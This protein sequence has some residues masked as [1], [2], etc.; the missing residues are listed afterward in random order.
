VSPSL[1]VLAPMLSLSGGGLVN[2][3]VASNSF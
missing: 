2:E 3:L 1:L